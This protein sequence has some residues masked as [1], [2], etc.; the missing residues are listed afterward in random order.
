M[1]KTL[2]EKIDAIFDYDTHHYSD[3]EQITADIDKAIQELREEIEHMGTYNGIIGLHLIEK[4]K[5][6]ALIGEKK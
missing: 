4:D 5:I 2:Q 3:P 6:L 1:T